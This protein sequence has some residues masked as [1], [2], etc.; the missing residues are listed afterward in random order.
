MID[1][2][3]S[4]MK[5][6]SMLET[7]ADLVVDHVE[8]AWLTRYPLSNKKYVDRCKDFL[9]EFKTMMANDYGIPCNCIRVRIIQAN[10][11][12]E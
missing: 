8:L 3:T 10:I 11:I 5:T 12:V 6:Y 9:A 1:P 4:C 2:A 7:R